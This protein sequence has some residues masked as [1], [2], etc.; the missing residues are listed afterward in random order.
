MPWICPSGCHLVSRLNPSGL[1][2]NKAGA[3]M[4]FVQI[5]FLP[6]TCHLTAGHV[7]KIRKKSVEPVKILTSMP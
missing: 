3:F 4:F 6:G 7:F 2:I 5:D 1:I